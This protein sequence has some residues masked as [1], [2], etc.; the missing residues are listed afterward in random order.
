MDKDKR[1]DIINSIKY[2]WSEYHDLEH[3]SNWKE[4][5]K[6]FPTIYTIWEQR[7]ASNLVLDIL[8]G[9]LEED[10]RDDNDN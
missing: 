10:W 9:Q 5:K 6:E 3:F 7:K 8:V 2:F 1:N 4:A